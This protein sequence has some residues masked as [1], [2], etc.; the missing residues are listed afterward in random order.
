MR[1]GFRKNNNKQTKQ[2]N[3]KCN[4]AD[5]LQLL[6][7]ADYVLYVNFVDKRNNNIIV[8]TIFL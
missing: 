7:V 3:V 2:N 1:K 4:V 6:H 8:I 5:Y